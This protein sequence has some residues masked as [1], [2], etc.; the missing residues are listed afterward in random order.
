M[1][2]HAGDLDRLQRFWLQGVCKP[3]KNKRNT[4]NPLDIN[5]FM[6]AFLLLGCGAVFTLVLLGLEHIYFKY[7]RQH[8]AKKDTGG[9]LALVSLSMGKSLTFRGA[10]YEAQDMLK[11]HRCKDPI[12]DTQLWKARHELD[13]VRIKLKQLQKEL[14]LR[15]SPVN[16]LKP[17][18]ITRN[19]RSTNELK[20][21]KLY[22]RPLRREIAEY[23]TVI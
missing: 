7:V 17:R 9:C 6:S 20:Q 1:S 15:T 16:S 12:C 23:E 2:V 8:L 18:D 14:H 5:Q 10:V 21:T 19:S 13:M 3:S 4:S 11:R 22:Y